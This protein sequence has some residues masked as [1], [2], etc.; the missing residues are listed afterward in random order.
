MGKK[1]KTHYK[2]L[3]SE[4]SVEGRPMAAAGRS[5]KRAIL[6]TALLL[7]LLAAGG[8]QRWIIHHARNKQG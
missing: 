3:D 5:M 7:A 2:S 1:A 6:T 8:V 4:S